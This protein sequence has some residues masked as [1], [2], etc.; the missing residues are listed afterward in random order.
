MS[1]RPKIRIPS[2]KE[3][4]AI[5]AGIEADPDAREIVSLKGAKRGRPKL[6]D[7]KKS[8]TLR[9]D[10]DVIEAFKSEGKGWQTRINTVLRESAG[11]KETT[12]PKKVTGRWVSTKEAARKTSA[13]S[14]KA[15]A[16]SVLSQR[17]NK[18]AKS[19][20]NKK[21]GVAKKHA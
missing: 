17:G 19:P 7:P 21:S 18:A 11:L 12:V 4:D 20:S 6:S 3:D 14:A 10:A 5:R 9:L 1:K 2:D 13:K 8:V 16:V 15:H